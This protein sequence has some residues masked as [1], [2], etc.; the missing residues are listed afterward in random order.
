M[1]IEERAY[2][3][4]AVTGKHFWLYSLI[5]RYKNWWHDAPGLERNTVLV[6]CFLTGGM[7]GAL[8]SRLGG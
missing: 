3:L 8:L 1:N 5:A 4:Y 7:V 6:A 2:E